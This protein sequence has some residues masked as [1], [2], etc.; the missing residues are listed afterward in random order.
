MRAIQIE[1]QVRRVVATYIQ[2]IITVLLLIN[3][4]RSNDL[5]ALNPHMRL[6]CVCSHHFAEGINFCERI[7]DNKM[8]Y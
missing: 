8:Y 1:Q 3:V 5:D 7:A 2:M 6:Y 4:K